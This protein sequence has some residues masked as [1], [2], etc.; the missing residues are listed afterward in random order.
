VIRV[1]V[2][3]EPPGAPVQE[4]GEYRGATLE[5]VQEEVRGAWPY[6]PAALLV[7]E[8]VAKGRG[9]QQA[10]TQAKIRERLRDPEVQRRKV[11]ARLATEAIRRAK[12]AAMSPEDRERLR[13]RRAKQYEQRWRQYWAGRWER[14]HDK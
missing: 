3:L 12:E 9:F 5:A 6:L 4:L 14:T 2:T 1:R 13:K 8:V 10:E 11:A 7:F